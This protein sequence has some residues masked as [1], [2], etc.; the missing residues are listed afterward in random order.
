MQS[1]RRSS[2]VAALVCF[3]YYL[4]FSVKVLPDSITINDPFKGTSTITRDNLISFEQTVFEGASQTKCVFHNEG[5]QR[6]VT[7]THSKFDLT[8]FNA[9]HL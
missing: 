3:Y 4:R 7:L 9:S 5:R 2:G 1:F 8:Q 6:S